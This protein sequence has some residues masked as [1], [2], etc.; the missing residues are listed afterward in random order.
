MAIIFRNTM[1]GMA[2]LILAGILFSKWLDEPIIEWFVLSQAIV[3]GVPYLLVKMNS[4][5]I[6]TKNE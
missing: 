6:R 1:F 5:S 3:M 2:L 4:D